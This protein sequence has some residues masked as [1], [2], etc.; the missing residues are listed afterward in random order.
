MI[1]GLENGKAFGGEAISQSL[2][3]TLPQV[4]RSSCGIEDVIPE[5]CVLLRALDNL[6]NGFCGRAIDIVVVI[7][8]ITHHSHSDS[9][10]VHGVAECSTMIALII[11][12]HGFAVDPIPAW[13]T[14]TGSLARAEDRTGF[15]M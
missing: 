2:K 4:E 7:V 1:L 11:Y 15:R 13:R 12:V 8:N 3:E 10:S 5:L 6:F 9:A 14:A